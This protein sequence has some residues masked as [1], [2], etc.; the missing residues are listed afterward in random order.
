MDPN[1]IDQGSTPFAYNFDVEGGSL[2]R[3]GTIYAKSINGEDGTTPGTPAGSVFK[4]IR[5]K[6]FAM[7][8]GG[9]GYCGLI[10]IGK[11]TQSGSES[12]D[13]RLYFSDTA[14]NLGATDGY[15]PLLLSKWF[16]I[17]GSFTVWDGVDFLK[18]NSVVF[19][20][21]TYQDAN[22]EELIFSDGVHTWKWDGGV[23]N[24][25]PE[26]MELLY[27]ATIDGKA[28]EAPPG[29]LERFSERVWV[30]KPEDQTEY[31]S[32]DMNPGNWTVLTGA[33]GWQMFPTW[34][35]DGI[36]NLWACF[37]G[38]ILIKNKS[39]HITEGRDIS[40]FS[41]RPISDT[42]GA[43]NG[44]CVVE[45]KGRVYILGEAGLNV[46]DGN[47]LT[48]VNLGRAQAIL[49]AWRGSR[50]FPVQ[51]Y[52]PMM[53]VF[54]DRLIIANLFVDVDSN[55]YHDA[56]KYTGIHFP[57][58]WFLEVNLKS[59]VTCARFFRDTYV[60]GVQQTS[61][62]PLTSLFVAR[63]NLGEYPDREMLYAVIDGAIGPYYVGISPES[64]LDLTL[65]TFDVP[66]MGDVHSW[67][68]DF[69]WETPETDFG[70]STKNKF[71]GEFNITGK[72]G[73]NGATGTLIITPVWDGIARSSKTIELPAAGGEKRIYLSGSGKRFKLRLQN[74][75]G[76]Y[77][78]IDDINGK[79]C[80]AEG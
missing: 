18:T 29:Y 16:S 50:K 61:T 5:V 52:M 11:T 70:D 71:L 9:Y 8:V 4:P 56:A 57:G 22:T 51:T 77:V 59:F 21:I 38:M 43:I 64:M 31:Y 10:A 72:G 79:V 27:S 66:S 12:N 2:R 62:I 24:H 39:T 25:A 26:A 68:V 55:T 37:E 3:C 46:W 23:T 47:A 40:E 32:D 67:G 49:D 14:L 41:S 13:I 6:A 28:V 17:K 44:E 65:Y 60:N 42:M 63:T 58:Q 76:D 78:K 19:D 1:D 48:P 33:A 15:D 20:C 53:A 54:E 7:K 45:Y 34:K 75:H 73:S 30:A 80:Y 35:D 74:A 69:Y 36:V